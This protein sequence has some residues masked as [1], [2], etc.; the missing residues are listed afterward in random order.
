[1]GQ[2]TGPDGWDESSGVGAILADTHSTQRKRTEFTER[3]KQEYSNI[4]FPSWWEAEPGLGRVADGVSNR[5]GQLKGYGNAQVP[6]QAA[7]AYRLLGEL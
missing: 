2:N 4:S 3:S 6:L 5:V 1:M 7:T